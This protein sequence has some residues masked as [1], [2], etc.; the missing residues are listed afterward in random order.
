MGAYTESGE[1]NEEY[2]SILAQIGYAAGVTEGDRNAAI[3]KG[4]ETL[5]SYNDSEAQIFAS[6]PTP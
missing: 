1:N 5:R 2:I 4:M 6:M 3:K